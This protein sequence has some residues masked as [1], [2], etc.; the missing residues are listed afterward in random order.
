MII[1]A[2]YITSLF[3]PVGEIEGRTESGFHWFIWGGYFR[4]GRGLV[5]ANLFFV[6]GCLFYLINLKLVAFVMALFTLPFAILG[7]FL[8]W[9]TPA[10]YAWI[11]SFILLMA[12]S[13][14]TGLK[15]SS[16]KTP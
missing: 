2:V 6:L 7:G 1:M 8:I 3:L 4:L 15:R 12:L 11:S 14:L 16:A 5:P 9:N 10:Y 13:F